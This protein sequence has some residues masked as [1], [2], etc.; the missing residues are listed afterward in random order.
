MSNLPVLTPEERLVAQQKAQESR[1]AKRLFAEQNLTLSYADEPYWR[2]TASLLKVRLPQRYDVGP[3]GIKKV[4]KALK[5]D[6]KEYL[7]STGFASLK[8]LCQANSTWTSLALSGLLIE[9]YVG[10]KQ[11]AV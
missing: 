4:A 5:V 3:K 8:D 11:N 2:E 6:I 9:W 1:E 7:A 10:E